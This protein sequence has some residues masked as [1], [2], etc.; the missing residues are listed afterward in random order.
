MY[1]TIYETTNTINGM[2]YIGKH[3]TKN[4]NDSY[5][6]SGIYLTNAIEKYGEANFNKKILFVFENENDMNSKE[7]E[8]VNEELIKNEKYYNIS[9]G[10]YGGKT[11]L[12]EEHPMYEEV[13]SKIS[14]A[15][16]N[17]SKEM[18]DIVKDLHKDKKVGMY[19][20][21]Q[22]DF[23]KESVS[24][25]LKGVKKSPESVKKQNESLMKTINAEGYVHPNTG[26]KATDETL[27]RMSNAV[28]SR[29][30]KTCE[31]CG[32][33][34]DPANYSRYHGD[35]CKSLINK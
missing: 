2:K 26:R 6:G 23:Q 24:K 7:R 19:G 13:C 32:T 27:K 29:P 22:S 18:S 21:K 12:Y 15:Q 1:Y 31:H 34:L 5:L 3:I 33:T 25:R 35:N 10:G 28:R 11:V 8:L 14:K 9:L 20:K 30:K 4:I 17:R 16:K